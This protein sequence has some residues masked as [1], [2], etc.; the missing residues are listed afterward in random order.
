MS[1]DKKSGKPSSLACVCVCVFPVFHYFPVPSRLGDDRDRPHACSDPPPLS[2]PPMWYEHKKVTPATRP[3]MQ[4]ENDGSNNN[5]VSSRLDFVSEGAAANAA[6]F[7]PSPPSS[8][9]NPLVQ[10]NEY[11]LRYG[12]EERSCRRRRRRDDAATEKREMTT[13]T[14]TVPNAPSQQQQQQHA[15]R[16]REEQQQQQQE[17]TD[18]L[19]QVA[20]FL[21]GPTLLSSALELIDADASASTG[22]GSVVFT[23]LVAPSGRAVH[24]VRGSGAGQTYL[25]LT[26]DDDANAGGGGGGSGGGI[27]YCSCRSYL[28]RSG[29]YSSSNNNNNA[30]ATAGGADVCG[31]VGGPPTL[32]P[33]GGAAAVSTSTQHRSPPLCKHLLALKLLPHLSCGGG[34]S[35][36]ENENFDDDVD[37]FDDFDALTVVQTV[38]EEEFAHLVMDR[39]WGAG[40]R[41]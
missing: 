36:D 37:A 35:C 38:T 20:E 1:N 16:R 34:Q 25:C 18:E 7:L 10:L 12:R 11:L 21:Y 28:E 31:G 6:L 15:L 32:P 29:R 41:Y 5:N 39:V 13:T 22:N 14:T 2:P 27:H 26:E 3:M 8:V 17:R 40:G 9:L 33:S 4:H 19:L 23:R 30:S 24:L